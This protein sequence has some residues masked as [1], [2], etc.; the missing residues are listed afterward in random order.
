MLQNGDV[1]A[2]SGRRDQLVNGMS[3]VAVEVEEHDLLD[4]SAEVVTARSCDLPG[5]RASVP[6]SRA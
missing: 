2:M 4:G 6:D 3:A 1:I 5:C